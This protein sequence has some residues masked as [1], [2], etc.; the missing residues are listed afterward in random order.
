M[1]SLYLIKPYLL[2]NRH[3]IILGI[4]CL[5]TVDFL[6]LIIPRVIKWA[7][8]DLTA[9]QADLIKLSLYAAYIVGIAI[10]DTSRFFRHHFAK[11]ISNRFM[12]DNFSYRRASLP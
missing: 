10:S 2:E 9:M 3:R 12:H 5:I 7:V 4:A 6:Q 1:K 11:P 8:D